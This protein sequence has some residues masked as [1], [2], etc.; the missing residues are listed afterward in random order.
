MESVTASTAAHVRRRRLMVAVVIACMVAMLAPVGSF[1]AEAAPPQA[2]VNWSPCHKDVG[3][4]FGVAYECTLVNVPLD[5]DKPRGASIQL[6]LVRL[7]ATDPGNRIGSVFINPGGPGGSGVEAV[8]FI[9]G[10]AA[11]FLWGPE[12]RERFDIVGFDPRGIARSSAM[13]C[14]GN[15][16]QSTQVFAPFAFPLTPD[17]EQQWIAGDTLLAEQCDKRGNRI[18]EH[19]STANVARDLDLLREAVGDEQLNYFGASYGSYLGAT[20]ANLFPDRVRSVIVDGI[21]DPIAWSNVEAE[22]PFSTRLRSDVGAQA[23]LDRFF[24]LCEEAAPGNCALAP[25]SSARYDALAAAVLANPVTIM[26][27]S[28]GEEIRVTYQELVGFTLGAL[29]DP[30]S[31]FFLAQDLAFLE[32]VVASS[33]SSAST[34]TSAVAPSSRA[35]VDR[36]VNRRGFPRYPNF[37]ESFPAVACSDT[38]NPSDYAVWSSEGAAADAAFGH[39]GRLWTWASSPCAQ[40][41]LDD[42]DAYEGPFTAETANDVLITGNLYDPATRYEGAQALRSLL[43]N[44]ALVTVD[45]AGHV[46]LGASGCAGFVQ[47]QYLLDP[48]IAPAL[49]GLFCPQEFNPIDLVAGDMAGASEDFGIDPRVRNRLLAEIGVR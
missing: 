35:Q 25:N 37:V 8:L 32:A 2:K 49:D 22:I 10:P 6:S 23:T 3:A 28:T 21:L 36:F 46:S 34:A 26:D 17:E 12:V 41:P 33:A 1:D 11:E 47:G 27:P 44:S 43:P 15:L 5:H 19:M 29:Y 40:W 18:G 7:P 42:A 20:Y 31:F 39:F 30:F 16:R 38:N 13:R 24:E 4:E 48:G 45:L 14:F 9:F